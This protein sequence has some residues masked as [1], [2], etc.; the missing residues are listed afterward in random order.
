MLESG[1]AIVKT[2]LTRRDPLAGQV[3]RVGKLSVGYIYDFARTGPV[4]WGVGALASAFRVPA[5]AA[6]AY[7]SHPAAYML[8]LQARL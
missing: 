4:R 8:F 6:P 3:M 2:A 7:G 1:D 5:E